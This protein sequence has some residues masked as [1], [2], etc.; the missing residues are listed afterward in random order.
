MKPLPV[1]LAS[2]IYAASELIAERG[3]DD[4]KIEDIA[5]VTG[6][7]VSTLY[8]HFRGKAE[9]LA[10]LLNDLLTAI[11]A[12]VGVAVRE[13]GQRRAC[14]LEQRPEHGVEGDQDHR[15]DHHL[16]LGLGALQE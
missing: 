6:I 11:A 5:E 15:R 3:L 13:Q 10:F 4:T 8:Y 7:P 1:Q 2:K 16:E 14:L 12:E 9:I